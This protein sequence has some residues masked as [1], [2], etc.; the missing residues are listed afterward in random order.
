MAQEP[1]D[2]PQPPPVDPNGPPD[3]PPAPI[4]GPARPAG[5][6]GSAPI[7]CS[8]VHGFVLNWGYRNEPKLPVDLVG[9]S[10][11][12]HSVTDD[13]GYY[14]FPCLAADA[15]LLNA[16]VPPGL[17]PM[18][19]DVAIRLAYRA[20]FEVNLGVYSGQVAPT[21]EVKPTMDVSPGEVW[22]G[23]SLTY[24]IQVANT[25]G[26]MEGVMITDMLPPSLTPLSATSS[27]GAT[28]LWGNLLTA[29]VGELAPGQS[30]TIAVNAA[31]RDGVSPGAVIGNRASLIYRDHVTVQTDLVSV[32]VGSGAP[33]A[34]AATEPPTSLPV[35]GGQRGGIDAFA[36]WLFGTIAR[37]ADSVL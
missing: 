14:A 32:Q 25:S 19:S 5:E 15:S 6:E 12:A 31:V 7:P 26:K 18:T 34:S 8:G 33:A 35:T 28:E 11:Q 4:I 37:L 10:W 3:R 13:N 29:D 1:P 2:R 21:L 30:V 16:L 36:S 9:E 24:T 17:R 27:Q 22:P 23:A 20:D